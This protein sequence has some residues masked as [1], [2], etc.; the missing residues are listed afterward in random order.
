[1]KYY[2]ILIAGIIIIGCG[3]GSGSADSVQATQSDQSDIT[4]VETQS[5]SEF[6]TTHPLD[7]GREAFDF[8][9]ECE[10]ESLLCDSVGTYEEPVRTVFESGA[11]ITT[12][13][14]IVEASTCFETAS[15]ACVLEPTDPIRMFCVKE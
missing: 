6:H 13:R 11:E 12:M 10:F 15:Y 5:C 2:K 3:D 1:M 4:L 14:M 9:E 8:F 7:E